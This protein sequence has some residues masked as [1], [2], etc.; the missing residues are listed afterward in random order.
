MSESLPNSSVR[1]RVYQYE[2]NGDSL[3]NPIRIL[4]LPA[5][6]GPNHPGGKLVIGKDG[7]LYTVIGDL[8][9]EGLLQNIKGENILTDTSVIIRIDPT[10][11]KAPEDNPF[12][13]LKP[14]H[15]ARNALLCIKLCELA[16]ESNKLNRTL[17][18]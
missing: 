4:D 10:S 15:N 2:W 14:T 18:V 6:P 11:G 12:F 9:N 5:T 16:E 1:N 8:N 13:N 7:Y 3:L 17:T